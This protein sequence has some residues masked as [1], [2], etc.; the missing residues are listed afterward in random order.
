MICLGQHCASA[1]KRGVAGG[2]SDNIGAPSEIALSAS[3]DLLCLM[4]LTA[5][6]TSVGNAI[7]KKWDKIGNV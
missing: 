7:I 3:G 1:D 2:R 6:G 5:G 4:T